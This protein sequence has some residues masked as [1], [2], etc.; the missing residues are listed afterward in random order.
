M[1]LTRDETE[2]LIRL[3]RSR[4]GN[5]LSP[6]RASRLAARLPDLLSDAPYDSVRQIAEHAGELPALPL[7]DRIAEALTIN[8]TSFFRDKSPFE[9]FRS[10]VL[11]KLI[12]ARI[13][14]RRLSIWSAACASGQEAYSIAMLLRSSFSELDSWNIRIVASDISSEMLD[15]T[16]EA[17][18]S[19]FEVR[20]GLPDDL[21]D[22]FLLRHNQNW[23]V[24]QDLREMV[25][26]RR[27]NLNET[28]PAMRKCDVVF[29]RN[30]LIYFDRATKEQIL[31]RIHKVMEP[32]GWLFIGGGETFIRLDVPFVDASLGTTTCFRPA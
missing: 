7:Y 1:A 19:D 14:T 9:T 27:V 18:Y 24:C 6:D 2:F 15:R 3:V 5:V 30:V 11:P 31:R 20:R 8:E 28:L 32:D 12:E 16:R 23:Q 10:T 22:R 26:C 13:D 21:R 17:V 4:T 25:K 29:L